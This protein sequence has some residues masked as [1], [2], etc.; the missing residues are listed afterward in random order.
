MD[1]KRKQNDVDQTMIIQKFTK[2]TTLAELNEKMLQL[3]KICEIRIKLDPEKRDHY[4]VTAY[5]KEGPEQ[6]PNGSPIGGRNQE[7]K[8]S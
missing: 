1:S 4:L 3:G 7:T 5:R 2:E 8:L 6:R